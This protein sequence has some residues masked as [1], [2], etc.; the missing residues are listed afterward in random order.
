[1]QLVDF[2]CILKNVEK[3][4]KKVEKN[5]CKWENYLYF[6]NVKKSK[7]VTSF[8]GDIQCKIEAKGRLLFPSIFKRQLDK[9]QNSFV[10]KKDIYEQ[11]L[12]LYTTE[13]WERQIAILRRKLNLYNKNHSKF[14][15]EFYR[16]TAKITMDNSGRLLIPKR[17]LDLVDIKKEIYMLGL[18][19]KIEIWAKEIYDTIETSQEE[20][21][22]LAQNILGEIDLNE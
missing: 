7:K 12:V 19:T 15:R 4:W 5:D 9:G 20:F 3:K 17:L 11:C 13:E 16:D 14:L 18:D 21:A 2:Q 22:E 10:V 1:L 6:Y 8:I